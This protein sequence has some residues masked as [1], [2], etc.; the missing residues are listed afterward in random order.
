MEDS[1]GRI[2]GRWFLPLGVGVLPPRDERPFIVDHRIGLLPSADVL[3]LSRCRVE[4]VFYQVA[5][6]M[7]I[8][9]TE[10]SSFDN[11]LYLF[12]RGAP[13]DT[14][15]G[16]YRVAKILL[17]FAPGRHRGMIKHAIRLLREPG[18][19]WS[20]ITLLDGIR[21]KERSEP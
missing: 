4:R 11:P 17:T 10:T 12:P 1:Y 21:I 3:V 20:K 13:R 15:R 6:L 9:N 19:Q 7:P 5:C 2:D 18:T 8:D 16:T 14:L